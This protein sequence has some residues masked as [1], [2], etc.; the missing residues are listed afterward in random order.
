MKRR[1]V[2]AS[3]TIDENSYTSML[4][5]NEKTD[6]QA[7]KFSRAI[8]RGFVQN[9]IDTIAVSYRK[10]T[11]KISSPVK[12]DGIEFHYLR[13]GRGILKYLRC[14]AQSYNLTKKF[15][16]D[17]KDGV[18]V[19]DGLNVFVSLGGL[20][21]AKKVKAKKIAVITDVPGIYNSG[22]LAKLNLFIISQFDE[23]IFL[24]EAMNDIL[25]KN[26][27]RY[28]VLEGIYAPNTTSGKEN[29]RLWGNPNTKKILY[30]GILDEKYGV[31]NL[32]EAMK[33]LDKNIELFLYG[34]GDCVELIEKIQD[35][36][37][38][39]HYYGVCDNSSIIDMEKKMDLLVNP[40]SKKEL[41][42]QYSFPS[43]TIEYMS[44]GTPV[45]MQ[46]LPGMPKEYEQYLYLY[47][48]DS[49]E[50][51]AKSIREVLSLNSSILEYKGKCAKDFIL[52]KKNAKNQMRTIC[53]FI[54]D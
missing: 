17:Y 10:N 54:F 12:S 16:T 40:R 3:S 32:I 9:D 47:E 2:Y 5:D 44:T 33:Y 14:F 42:T 45:L 26:R 22:F 37:T 36:D 7:Q 19:A 53:N 4:F 49:P 8:L 28:I 51:L 24:T 30:A 23:F 35:T 27:K 39:I 38:R 15:L 20:L 18:F 6:Q 29:E 31:K 50:Q 46:R 21:G 13:C 1:V 34:D 25:N 11:E 43:K 41:F 48:G 52:S